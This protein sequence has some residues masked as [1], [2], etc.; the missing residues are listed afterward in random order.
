MR[1][2]AII[3]LVMSVGV[4]NASATTYLYDRPF[5]GYDLPEGVN[6]WMTLEVTPD[7]L[8]FTIPA[9]TKS[10]LQNVYFTLADPDQVTAVIG[11]AQLGTELGPDAYNLGLDFSGKGPGTYQVTLEGWDG[12]LLE[13]EGGFYSIAA[14]TDG[15]WAAD[16]PLPVPDAGSTL[17]MLG[18][19][20][21]GLSRFRSARR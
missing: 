15:T 20:L 2:S 8:T 10:L 18:I 17:I 7:H 13:P 12:N 9:S 5:S 1:K 19:G 4:L 11:D 16:M 21:L 14:F 6:P 3:G